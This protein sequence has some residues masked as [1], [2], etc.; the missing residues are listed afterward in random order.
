MVTFGISL[1]MSSN[2]WVINPAVLTQ[3][4]HIFTEK[5]A[6]FLFSQ[7]LLVLC[8]TTAC[9]SIVKSMRFL[10]SKTLSEFQLEWNL[11]GVDFYN[12]FFL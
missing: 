11:V 6:V 12:L 9:A 10:F 2:S 7:L 4:T 3:N 1:G 5:V 8:I